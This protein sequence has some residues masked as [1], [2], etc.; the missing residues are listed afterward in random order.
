[1]IRFNLDRLIMATA[2]LLFA[3]GAVQAAPITSD[4]AFFSEEFSGPTLSS[5]WTSAVANGGSVS[6]PTSP[7]ADVGTVFIASSSVS[8][9]ASIFSTG[10]TTGVINYGAATEWAVETRFNIGDATSLSIGGASPRNSFLLLGRN[11]A[12][13]ATIEYLVSLRDGTAGTFTL[14]WDGWLGTGAAITDLSAATTNLNRNTYY[15]LVLHHRTDNNIDFYLDNVLV[16]TK[17]AFTGGTPSP[18]LY[19]GDASASTALEAKIDYVRIG[20]P[21]PEP[22]SLCLLGLGAVTILAHRQ[23]R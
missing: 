6:F 3:A 19:I 9:D 20:N 16:A 23:W 5:A 7:P 4:G 17:P 1:M 8:R 13:T 11:A 10:T 12:N 18:R 21:V 22:G 2:Y 15:T 14:G